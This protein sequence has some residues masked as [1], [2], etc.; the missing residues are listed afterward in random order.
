MSVKEAV[1]GGGDSEM[2][3]DSPSL[4]HSKHYHHQIGLPVYHGS[5]SSSQHHIHH[6]HREMSES[7]HRRTRESNNEDK[8]HV[9]AKGTEGQEMR[10]SQKSKF[11]T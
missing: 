11:L 9:K 10:N 1:S 3:C 8:H 6:H 2:S 4:K 5:A 7:G